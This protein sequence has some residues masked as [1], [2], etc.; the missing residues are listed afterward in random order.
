MIPIIEST[1][2]KLHF[3]HHSDLQV[4]YKISKMWHACIFPS[5]F[6][7]ERN[8][9]SEIFQALAWTLGRRIYWK[10]FV[11]YELYSPQIL[12]L[13]SLV[14]AH[15]AFLPSNLQG[16]VQ[17]PKM[18]S[19]AS[20]NTFFTCLIPKLPNLSCDAARAGAPMSPRSQRGPQFQPRVRRGDWVT[21]HKAPY[22]IKG[23]GG[24]NSSS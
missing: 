4:R 8:L 6:Q 20:L 7:L 18:A 19:S 3:S 17:S 9:G 23:L 5:V 21:G 16:T 12:R 14:L 22:G 10:V 13:S 24:R 11:G 1:R 15:W 2:I